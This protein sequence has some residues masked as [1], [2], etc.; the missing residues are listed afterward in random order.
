VKAYRGKLNDKLTKRSQNSKQNLEET[1]NVVKNA[2]NKSA[3]VF[4]KGN[5]S[6]GK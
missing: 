3:E 5:T 6:N 2:I 1:W 4:K